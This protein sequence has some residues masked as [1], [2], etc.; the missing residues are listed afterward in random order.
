MTRWNPRAKGVPPPVS[1][2]I[3]HAQISVVHPPRSSSL[4]FMR[5]ICIRSGQ[6]YPT[7]ECRH[8]DDFRHEI[9]EDAELVL[10]QEHGYGLLNVKFNRNI[11]PDAEW[12]TDSKYQGVPSC[13][14]TESYLHRESNHQI[15]IH[16]HRRRGPTA[17]REIGRLGVF[18]Y[19]GCSTEGSSTFWLTSKKYGGIGQI[20]EVLDRLIDGGLVVTDG[21]M[22]EG[23]GNPYRELCRFFGNRE[24]GFNAVEQAETFQDDEDRTF[25]CVGYAGEKYG[26]TLVW[27]VR[28]T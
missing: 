7:D 13:I 6:S 21:S 8:H 12:Q 5:L 16:R 3:L 27:Q 25:R 1:E 22:C 23:T 9:P 28:R 2:R 20:D 11:V 19:R 24:P 17:M 15:R 4:S 14:R 10:R 18:F 26:P